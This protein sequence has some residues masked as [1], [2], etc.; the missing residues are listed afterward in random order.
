MS[1]DR[2]LIGFTGFVG[3]N[4]AEQTTFDALYNSAN[5]QEMRGRSYSLVVCAGVSGV[6]W[7]GNQ[8]PEGDWRGIQTLLD[9]LGAISTDKLVLIS[10][11]DVYPVSGGVDESFDCAS[12]ENHPYGTH[13]LAVEDF[14]RENF[15]SHV[16][17]R[18]PALFGPGLKKNVIF[19]LLNEHALEAI[20]PDSAFQ[21]YDVRDLWNDFLRVD[22]A[23]LSLVNLFTEPIR[24][25]EIMEKF[26]PD[27]VVGG[28]APA[29][30]YSLRTQFASLRNR[31]GPY[32]Y[33]R[34]EILAKLGAYVAHEQVGP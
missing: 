1:Q 19:D 14:C 31:S 16:I 3:S 22:A 33:G 5:I 25:S 20:N 24:V 29:H 17:L 13:R 32:L 27:T 11:I 28:Q 34:E 18:L 2:A 9:V 30:A 21:Y 7:K 15:P 23:G 10:T 4:L 26:F 6:K 8:D 12:Q